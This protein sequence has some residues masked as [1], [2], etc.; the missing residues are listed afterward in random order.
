MSL[1]HK[2]ASN[3]TL[4]FANYLREFVIEAGD[5]ALPAGL[6]GLMLHPQ[7]VKLHSQS[8]DLFLNLDIIQVRVF[9]IICNQDKSFPTLSWTSRFFLFMSSRAAF[10]S[11]ISCSLLVTS[12]QIVFYR[13]SQVSR[14]KKHV[15]KFLW[16]QINCSL[17]I[18]LSGN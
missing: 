9:M 10:F 5:D 6:I 12:W 17:V 15:N 18:I 13:Q 3:P 14:V 11:D 2:S 16:W 7:L 1:Q 8:L 4:R